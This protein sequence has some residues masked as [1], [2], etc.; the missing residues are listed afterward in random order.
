MMSTHARFTCTSKNHWR[1]GRKSFQ[2]AYVRFYHRLKMIIKNVIMW[3]HIMHQCVFV[4]CWSSLPAV[5]SSAWVLLPVLASVSA[6]LSLCGRTHLGRSRFS[7]A[8]PL[9]GAR[10]RGGGGEPHSG[11]AEGF[12]PVGWSRHTADCIQPDTNGHTVSILTAYRL[13]KLLQYKAECRICF[14]EAFVLKKRNNS[15]QRSS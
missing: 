7:A 6:C 11:G 9:F 5:H 13:D 14:F 10:R 8:A 4:T 1:L 12:G 2:E 3:S 15:K